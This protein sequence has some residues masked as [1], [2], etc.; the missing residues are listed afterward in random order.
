MMFEWVNGSMVLLFGHHHL[1][2]R[3]KKLYFTEF[4]ALFYLFCCES[5]ALQRLASLLIPVNEA[6]WPGRDDAT[7]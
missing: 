7:R 3:L 4:S 1:V 5:A 2:G 6:T